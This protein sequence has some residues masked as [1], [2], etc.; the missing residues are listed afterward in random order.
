MTAFDHLV[1]ATLPLVPKALVRKVASRYVAGDTL[2]SALEAMRALAAE[3][4]MGTMDVL[5]ESV[6]H[7]D[8]TVATRD[9][10]L[11]TID[12]IAASGLPA[13]V[14]VKPSRSL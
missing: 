6:T 9:E 10:Y 12:A 1:V 11:R 4:A 7:R 3:G 14:S 2:E 5:G 13:N 8:Q